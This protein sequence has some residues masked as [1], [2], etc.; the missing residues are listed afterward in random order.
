LPETVRLL[1]ELNYPEKFNLA[2]VLLDEHVRKRRDKI[3]VYFENEMITYREL[4]A[5]VNRFANALRALGV[6]RNERIMLRSPN[7]PE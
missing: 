1:P 2:D 3:A 7:V 5:M 6:E 4:Q